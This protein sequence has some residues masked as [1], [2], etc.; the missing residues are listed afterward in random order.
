M[1]KFYR[2]LA[3]VLCVATLLTVCAFADPAAGYGLNVFEDVADMTSYTFSDISSTDWSFGGIKAAYDKGI[4]LG[5]QDG[6]FRPDNNVT[7]GQALVIA[8][9]IHSAYFGNALPTVVTGND[10]WYTP[11]QRYCDRQGMIPS[12]CPKNADLDQIAIPRY[13]LA[14]IFCRTIDAED[15]PAI[16]DRQI[17]DLNK[18][19]AE[20]VDSVKLMYSSGVMNGWS[21]YSFGGDRLTTRE[22][23][24]VVIDRLLLPA[25]R[26]GHD[27]KVN[28][29]MAPFEA[30]LENDSA[31]V[32]I[33]SN[34]YCVYKYYQTT[35][36]EL[37]ALYVTTGNNDAKEL[38]TCQPGERLDNLSVFNGKVYFCVSTTGTCNGKLMCYNPSTGAFSTVYEGFATE[39]YCFYNGKIYA[40]L[41]TNYGE[42]H[43]Y[44]D[45]TMDLSCWTYQFGKIS[46]GEF[47]ALLDEMNYNQAMYF[48]PYGWNGC[49]YFKLAEPVTVGSG[50][51]TS[52]TYAARLYEYNLA[53]GAL[54]KLSDININT[55][56][57]EGHV[58]YFMAYDNEGNYDMTLYAMSLQTPGVLKAIGEFPAATDKRYRSIYKYDDTFYCLSS[59]NRN[60]YSMDADGDTRIALM[61]GGIYNACCFTQDGLVLIPTTVAT[62]NVNEIKF[63][64]AKSLA[65]RELLGDW[66]GLS[67]YYKGA[68]FVPEDGQAVYSSGDESVSTVS[69]IKVVVP[70]AFMRDDELIVRAKYTNYNMGDGDGGAESHITLR[71]YVVKVYQGNK[72]VAYD[73]NK[74]QGMEMKPYDI[75]TYTFVISGDDI[76]GDIDVSA[77]DFSIEIVPTYDVKVVKDSSLKT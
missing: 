73:I 70:E 67:C 11:Y 40:L 58:M 41:F 39:S 17:T 48:V 26:I 55:S 68:R 49:I 45:G 19:P 71:M 63:Y 59:L 38:Y 47:T 35:S 76:T 77:D 50:N 33:G 1:K 69:E 36:T 22:Q 61:C 32:Q 57:F 10:D 44:A 28:S 25:D 72:L 3:A 6:T 24:A 51:N 13:A 8:A 64:N 5:Y 12:D 74:M 2:I 42:P 18:I 37:Y 21:D 23:I 4:L 9:R 16:S 52:E 30:N 75:Q 31:A 27:S 56:F 54:T 43:V 46:G 34:Y 62:S 20:Y 14:Y 29:A 66:M 53:S 15:M 65:S 60:L 7:W